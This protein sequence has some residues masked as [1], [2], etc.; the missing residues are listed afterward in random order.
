MI[1]REY[2]VVRRRRRSR[3]RW[4]LFGIVCLAGATSCATGGY[5]TQGDFD[6]L[7]RRRHVRS[8]AMIEFD[9]DSFVLTSPWLPGVSVSGELRRE[10]PVRWT[11][12]IDEVEIVANWSNGWTYAVLDAS[13]TL[14]IEASG[15]T[16]EEMPPRVTVDLLDTI[17]LWTLRQGEIRYFDDYIRR[18]EGLARVQARLDRSE[19]YAEWLGE[20]HEGSEPLRIGHAYRDGAYGEPV[21]ERIE[22][23]LE[24]V[25]DAPPEWIVPLLESGTVERDL[26]ESAQLIQFFVNSVYVESTVLSGET[27]W[28]RY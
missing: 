25:G 5:S 19:A 24:R 11:G 3:L 27:V 15:V 4:A 28:E 10:S 8:E 12:Y 18:E 17:D 21:G 2:S 9:E 26:L 7:G 16:P 23:A 14:T 1:R 20:R 6:H 22:G 13:G